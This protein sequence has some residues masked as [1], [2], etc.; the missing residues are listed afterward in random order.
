MKRAV[1]AALG[2]ALL[3]GAGRAAEV[4]DYLTKDGK[5][6]Q[7]L[8]FRDGQGGFA[9]VTGIAWAVETDGSYTVFTFLNDRVQKTLRKGKLSEKQLAALAAHLAAQ[10]VARLPEALG[11]FKGA[12]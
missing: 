7:P 4:G 11:G 12:N 9:G 6:K 1:W 3:A 8:E 5:L 10:D 2:L